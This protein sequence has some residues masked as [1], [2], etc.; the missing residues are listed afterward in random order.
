MGLLTRKQ[1][2]VICDVTKGYLN[3][4]I[5]R[6]SVV[7]T[8]KMIDDTIPQ[9]VYFIQK[10]KDKIATKNGEEVQGKL[11][12][13]VKP[14]SKEMADEAI[15]NEN[16]AVDE[17][18]LSKYNLELQ[19]RELDIIK[20]EEEIEITKM[21]RAKMAGELIPT[22]L[23]LLLFAS[24]FKNVT[25]SFHQATEILIT[26][27]GKQNNLDRKQIAKI[28]GELIDI[29]NSA[30]N[31]GMDSSK[32]ELKNLVIEYSAKRERGERV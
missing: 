20:T 22:D 23:V 9:N 12:K 26:T 4:Y 6:G 21:K 32:K 7:L 1:I 14:V 30:I 5:G 29:I 28:R 11:K 8:G 13:Y 19:K 16:G 15:D 17:H 2:C 10:H 31:D 25:T 24:H 18:S 3:V 27:I